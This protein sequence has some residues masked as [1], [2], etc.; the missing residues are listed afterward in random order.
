[1]TQCAFGAPSLYRGLKAR[2]RALRWLAAVQTVA[3]QH[4]ALGSS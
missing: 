1:M 3:L 4:I 2:L